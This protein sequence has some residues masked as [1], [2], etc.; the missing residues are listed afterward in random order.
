MVN[1]CGFQRNSFHLGGVNPFLNDLNSL[2]LKFTM[3]F[4]TQAVGWWLGLPGPLPRIRGSPTPPCLTPWRELC[5]HRHM[6]QVV[7]FPPRLGDAEHCFG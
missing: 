7:L 4:L 5:P 1:M 3:K 2:G 6:G